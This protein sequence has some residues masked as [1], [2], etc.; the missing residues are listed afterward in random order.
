MGT[1][2][3]GISRIVGEGSEEVEPV[4]LTDIGDAEIEPFD[5]EP[6]TP[7]ANGIPQEEPAVD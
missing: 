2:G 5:A 4:Q 3:M 7:P 6:A 1:G